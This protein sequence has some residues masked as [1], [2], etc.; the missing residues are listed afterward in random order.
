MVIFTSRTDPI[1]T[2]GKWGAEIIPVQ[3]L[4]K[5]FHVGNAAETKSSG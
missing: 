4:I 2:G 1:E 3:G 5:P